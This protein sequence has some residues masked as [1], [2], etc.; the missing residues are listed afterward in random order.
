[1]DDDAVMAV[2]KNS[3]KARKQT[4][5]YPCQRR[6]VKCDRGLPCAVCVARGHSFLC[7]YGRPTETLKTS[8]SFTLGSEES[9]HS[10]G[11]QSSPGSESQLSALRDQ[12]N[13]LHQELNQVRKRD[14]E[15]EEAEDQV[16]R[17]Q[18]RCR[19][20]EAVHSSLRAGDW[21]ALERINDIVKDGSDASSAS[22]A[23]STSSISPDIL[24]CPQDA[25]MRDGTPYSLPVDTPQAID[26]STS[27]STLQSS[28]RN[29][30]S[31]DNQRV[32]E[33]ST[34]TQSKT[35]QMGPPTRDMSRVQHPQHYFQQRET[36]H[37]STPGCYSSISMDIT[38]LSY[39]FE[40]VS[41]CAV[42]P[43]A[44][45]ASNYAILVH[46]VANN[47]VQGTQI[48][49]S[50]KL[51][52]NRRET[53]SSHPPIVPASALRQQNQQAR[54]GQVSQAPCFIQ[55]SNTVLS[56]PM[57]QQAGMA[58]DSTWTQVSLFPP[59]IYNQD[60]EFMERSYADY[61]ARIV[62]E[63]QQSTLLT[64]Q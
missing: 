22:G 24:L 20:Y 36:A 10:N 42:Q 41:N 15:C 25:T 28:R 12:L 11:R 31:T 3:R 55:S 50:S 51:P 4:T 61:W 63:A 62:V 60:S 38:N 40:G 47:D 2:L 45:N 29:L 58:S 44:P 48:T 1:M 53:P 8:S 7:S 30:V 34:F 52:E 16:R 46:Q 54:V 43:S 64:G 56:D 33:S 19:E 49:G 14:R 35:Q 57:M 18:A 23:S 17:L 59:M 13:H 27:L 5:C 9:S 37:E 26:V 39:R 6:K 21:S 32:S